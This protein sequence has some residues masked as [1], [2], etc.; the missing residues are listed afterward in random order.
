MDHFGSA[1]RNLKKKIDV[2][3]DFKGVTYET[4]IIRN[5]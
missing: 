3:F 4:L 1:E 2:V 5:S